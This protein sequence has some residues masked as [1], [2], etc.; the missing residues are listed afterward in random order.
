MIKT[1]HNS[2]FHIMCVGDRYVLFD[3]HPQTK[4]SGTSYAHIGH[5]VDACLSKDYC[6]LE[7]TL[8]LIK[9]RNEY[10]T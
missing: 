7:D 3:F 1:I 9:L 6:T 4:I 10:D 2:L 5:L 8:K